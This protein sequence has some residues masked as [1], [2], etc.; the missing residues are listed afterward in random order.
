MNPPGLRAQALALGQGYSFLWWNRVRPDTTDALHGAYAA[1]GA[2]GQ[3]IL[4][5]PKLDMVVAHKVVVRGAMSAEQ[6]VTLQ[7][8]E[9][10]VRTIVSARCELI[11]GGAKPSTRASTNG[12]KPCHFAPPPY[13]EQWGSDDTFAVGRADAPNKIT[14]TIAADGRATGLVVR[15]NG[16]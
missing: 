2:F 12:A 5:I 14:F 13:T 8:F 15:Y 7:D 3:Y 4:V 6:S 1:E 10:L 11:A 9:K 16:N